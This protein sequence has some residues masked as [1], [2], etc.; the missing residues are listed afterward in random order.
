MRAP[1]T[2]LAASLLAASWS[3]A[4]RADEPPP[5]MEDV[6]VTG[7]RPGPGMWHVHR[8]AAHVWILGSMSPLPKGITWRSKQVKRLL[9][10][11][12]Q[13]LVQ[14]PFELGIV[15]ILWLLITEHKVLMVG[16]GKRLKDV[17]PADLYARFAV[18]RTKY[19]EDP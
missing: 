12:G 16:G 7:E 19:G 4:C 3:M 13:V 2:L 5:V 14:K 9:D 18:L 6:V 10:S 17:M 1:S 8:G 11:T 15:R